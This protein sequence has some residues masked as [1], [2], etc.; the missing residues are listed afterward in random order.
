MRILPNRK[1]RASLRK[2]GLQNLCKCDHSKLGELQSILN[3]APDELMVT[4]YV[5]LELLRNASRALGFKKYSRLRKERIQARVQ[6]ILED[7]CFDFAENDFTICALRHYAHLHEVQNFR[8][9]SKEELVHELNHIA[10]D[11]SVFRNILK[12]NDTKNFYGK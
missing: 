3:K 5:S 1:L 11:K 12:P 7:P 8:K 9:L 2:R 6:S 4:K 10:I